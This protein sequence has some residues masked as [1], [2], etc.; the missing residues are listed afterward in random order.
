MMI[1]MTPVV[2]RYPPRGNLQL[3]RYDSNA[4]FEC[5]RCRKTKVSKLQAVVNLEQPRIICNA[6]YGYL[7]SLAEIKAQNI[8]PWVKAE[9]IHNL[10]IKEA[11]AKQAT[12]ATERQEQ[13]LKQ[14]WKFLSN[15]ARSFIGTAEYLYERMTGRD[16]LDF[17]PLIIE[18]VKSFEHQCV[19]GFLDPM[20]NKALNEFPK[21]HEASTDCQDKDFGRMAKYIFGREMR[22]PELGAIAHALVTFIQSRKRIHES[23]FLKIL[24]AHLSSCRDGEYF[25]NQERF[26]AQVFKLT[27][28]YRNPAAHIGSMSKSAFEECRAMLIGPSGILWQLVTATRY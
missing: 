28:S 10:T 20:K 16:D 25:L 4:P 3:I 24:D 18:L 26:V 8:E 11:S 7:L 13:R 6:C 5:W 19:I 21:E 27:Q 2:Q 1:A 22:P 17:S 15:E 12:Q 9:Q 14:Y 23:T